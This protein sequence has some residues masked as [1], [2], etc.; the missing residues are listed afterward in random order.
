MVTLV[1]PL[2]NEIYYA[3][4]LDT[5]FGP[6]TTTGTSGGYKFEFPSE[7]ED[8]T[9]SRGI[10]HENDVSHRKIEGSIRFYPLADESIPM[11]TVYTPNKVRY[12]YYN[13]LGTKL[14]WDC[15]YGHA[16]QNAVR[17]YRT[18][19]NG[20]IH[21]YQAYERDPLTN[22]WL[23]WR[24]SIQAATPTYVDSAFRYR[25]ISINKRT[26]YDSANLTY[27]RQQFV[28]YNTGTNLLASPITS[29]GRIK[30]LALS[31]PTHLQEAAPVTYPI[32]WYIGTISPYQSPAV[33]RSKLNLLMARLILGN[34]FFPLEEMPMGDLAMKASE[35]VNAN[36][37]NMI[38]F[39]RDLRH[40]TEMIPK[41]KNL[42]SLRTISGNY[43]SYQYGVLPTISDIQSIVESFKRI[44]PYLDRNGFS[45]Y[46]AGHTD[47]IEQGDFTYS[48]EQHIKLAID[49]ED[50]EFQALIQRLESIGIFPTFENIWDLVPYS[51]VLDWLIDVGGFLE[52]VDTRLRL[53]RLNIRYATMSTKRTIEGNIFSSK[54]APYDGTVKWVLY[55]RWV[56]DHCP[57]PALSLNPT[58]Q[59]FS[60]WLESGALL[61][62]RIKR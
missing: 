47:S 2:E 6:Y 57:V 5:L 3:R 19:T 31:S 50:D 49:H 13:Y 29:I 45:T 60:H 15:I 54:G 25:L 27:A 41:L 62:Q 8:M 61:A 14:S 44:S 30:S 38:A 34:V 51:F 10:W 23:I 4:F 33:T 59:D 28:G 9:E 22:E 21:Q 36:T 26:N 1:T 35:K 43:L 53:A 18:G 58:F 40:P 37:V 20:A 11:P 56:D 48:L 24:V 39:L 17:L 42:L 12:P 52:R 7:L 16:Q 32:D 55:H 46:S